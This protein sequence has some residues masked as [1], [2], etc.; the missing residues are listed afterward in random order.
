MV[1][2]VAKST[3]QYSIKLVAYPASSRLLRSWRITVHRCD[4]L[5]SMDSSITKKAA[6][7]PYCVLSAESKDAQRNFSQQSSVIPN[8]MSPVWNESFDLPVAKAN[9]HYLAKAL[10]PEI[11]KSDYASLFGY[12]AK[13]KSFSTTIR[14]GMSKKLM[15][16]SSQ[17]ELS[18]VLGTDESFSD[19]CNKV[20][21][22]KMI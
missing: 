8:E 4:N 3:I 16:S 2:K 14:K 18:S 9:T 11:G 20:A 7:D 1:N 21:M 22:V 17:E 6:S 15:H 10:G 12:P 19:W 13:K 5:P